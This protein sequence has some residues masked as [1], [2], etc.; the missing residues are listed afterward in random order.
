M[1]Q[2]ALHT[3]AL[4]ALLSVDRAI[5]ELR[6]GRAVTVRATS[7]ALL[8]VLA[9]ETADRPALEA[10]KTLGS[11]ASHLILTARRASALH[12]KSGAGEVVALTAPRDMDLETLIALADPTCDRPSALPPGVSATLPPAGDVREA[13]VRLAK[14]ARLL[15]AAVV[16]PLATPM[17]DMVE[18]AEEDVRTYDE[19]AAQSLTQVGE[20]RTPLRGAEDAKVIAFRPADGGVEHLAIVIGQPDRRKP[21]L[22]RLHSECFT[23][24]LLGSLRCDCGDQ[25]KGAIAEIGQAG[26]GVLLYLAQEGRGIGLVN[27]LRAYQLQDRGFDTLDANGQLGFDDDERIFLPAAEMLRQ[28]GISAVRLMT[29]N[30][31]KVEAL[32]RHG[33]SVIERV[34]HIFPANGHNAAYLRTKATKGGHLF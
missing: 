8:A 34:P 31:R 4:P 32:A 21:V 14:L 13:A 30:P 2:L 6:R 24:D 29:N 11:G 25:L 3:V 17:A 20:A 5:G 16:A 10:L 15:P 9:V 33:V 22:V 12:V 1:T 7:G 26:A 19:R 18:V 27:K 28:L 23:G